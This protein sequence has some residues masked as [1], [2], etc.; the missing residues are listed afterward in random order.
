MAISITCLSFK[1]LIGAHRPAGTTFP[2]S[3]PGVHTPGTSSSTTTTV[4]AMK[5]RKRVSACRFTCL[6]DEV[7]VMDSA[8]DATGNLLS[9]APAWGPTL[10][11][12]FFLKLVSLKNNF[13]K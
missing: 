11:R 9:G 13:R 8:V 5:R 3:L 12:L 10:V 6:G 1:F 2:K 4:M 7:G